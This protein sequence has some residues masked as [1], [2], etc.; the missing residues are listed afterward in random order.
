MSTTSLLQH[1]IQNKEILLHLTSPYQIRQDPLGTDMGGLTCMHAA[2]TISSGHRCLEHR[3][4]HECTAVGAPQAHT[5]AP[6]L[7]PL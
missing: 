4:L 2:S 3:R 1:F 7:Q 5:H 6:P